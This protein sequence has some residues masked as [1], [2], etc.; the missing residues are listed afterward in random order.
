M[1]S[2]FYKLKEKF[3]KVVKME[4]LRFE[5][6]AQKN[7]EF[8]ITF[9]RTL[10]HYTSKMSNVLSKITSGTLVVYSG[11]DLQIKGSVRR[12]DF[13][14]HCG[15]LIKFAIKNAHNAQGG[16]HIPAGGFHCETEYMDEF[17]KRAILFMKNNLVK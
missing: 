11:D 17:K 3:D 16:G 14:I 15:D 5:K 7:K 4:T 12:P 13:K 6:E 2:K 10:P 9:F 8:D 1:N